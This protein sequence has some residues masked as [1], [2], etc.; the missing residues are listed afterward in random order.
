M[1]EGDF[2]NFFSFPFTRITA[3]SNSVRNEEID[4]NV[5][6]D[7]RELRDLEF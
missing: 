2:T 5:A 3:C 1:E 4:R 7:D 6:E